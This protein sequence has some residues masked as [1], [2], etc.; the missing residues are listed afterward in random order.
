MCKAFFLSGCQQQHVWL[1]RLDG[2]L[3]VCSYTAT[4]ATHDRK[5][6][7][8]FFLTERLGEIKGRRERKKGE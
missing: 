6:T 2:V 8:F 4:S 1:Y 3:S 7:S 5:K